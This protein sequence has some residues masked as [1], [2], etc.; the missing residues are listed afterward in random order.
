MAQMMDIEVEQNSS[1]V[2]HSWLKLQA[3]QPPPLNRGGG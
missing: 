1:S 2:G 3:R